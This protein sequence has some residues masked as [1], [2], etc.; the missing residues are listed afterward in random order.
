MDIYRD[1]EPSYY[2]VVVSLQGSRVKGAVQF[3][4]VKSPSAYSDRILRITFSSCRLF[5]GKLTCGVDSVA[6]FHPSNQQSWSHR[7]PACYRCGFC[8]GFGV[9]STAL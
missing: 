9:N 6:G 2:R 1:P 4:Q 5:M 7:E 8:C 3:A